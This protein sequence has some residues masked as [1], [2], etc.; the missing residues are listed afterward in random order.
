MKKLLVSL[1]LM[2]SMPLVAIAAEEAATAPKAEASTAKACKK[3][4]G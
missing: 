4:R 3:A 1:L 2:T